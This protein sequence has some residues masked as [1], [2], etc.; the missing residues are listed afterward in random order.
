MSD[1][2][3]WADV[4]SALKAKD[5][6]TVTELSD[7]IEVSRSGDPSSLRTFPSASVVSRG[8]I[9]KL[10]RWYGISTAA[11]FPPTNPSK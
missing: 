11:C 7:G 3:L 1:G 8:F 5:G 2:A 9:A 4:V 6:L 10:E